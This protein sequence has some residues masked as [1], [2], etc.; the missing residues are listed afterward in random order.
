VFLSTVKDP[1]EPEYI[2]NLSE[3]L[4][5]DTE[6]SFIFRTLNSV[7]TCILPTLQWNKNIYG[8]YGYETN[9]QYSSKEEVEE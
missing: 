2:L 3:L 4:T 8:D 5:S 9:N 6:V 7:L 1:N